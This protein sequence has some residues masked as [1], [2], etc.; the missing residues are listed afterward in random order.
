MQQLLEQQEKRDS[1]TCDHLEADHDGVV[2]VDV[3]CN[4]VVT[5]EVTVATAATAECFVLTFCKRRRLATAFFV[6]KVRLISSFV[7][8]WLLLI[9]FHDI[10]I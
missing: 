1:G 9:H 2:V 7:D 6:F 10:S 4:T 3:A 5:G 8:I